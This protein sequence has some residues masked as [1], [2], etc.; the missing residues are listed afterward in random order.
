MGRDDGPDNEKPAHSETVRDF[1]IDKTEVTNAQYAEFV[2]VTHYSAP[3][4]EDGEQPYWKPWVSDKPPD[5]QEN[6]P[7]RNVSEVEAELYANWLSARDKKKYRLPTEKEWEFVARNGDATKLYPWGN[8]WK[9]GAANIDS[10]LPQAVGSFKDGATTTGV[11]DL[12]GNVQEWTSSNASIYPRN[13]AQLKV[14][15]AEQGQ[16]IVR[17]GSYRDKAREITA[18]YR[19]WFDKTTKYPLIGFRLVR[20]P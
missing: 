11:L 15:P 19:Q 9:N 13:P 17:G 5:G 12:I 8:S 4:N 10:S 6:W 2:Q 16:L 20:V 18:T 14:P 7:V 3:V 1:Y